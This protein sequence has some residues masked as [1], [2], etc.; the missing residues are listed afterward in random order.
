MRPVLLKS[1]SIDLERERE[2]EV[3]EEADPGRL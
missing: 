3:E 1:C 2:A